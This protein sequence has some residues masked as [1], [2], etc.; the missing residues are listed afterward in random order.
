MYLRC[1][2]SVPVAPRG[3]AG[4]AGS[5]VPGLDLL[6]PGAHPL[7]L[8]L[9]PPA[10]AA[11]YRSAE[12]TC[13]HTRPHTRLHALSHRG[14]CVHTHTHTHTHGSLCVLPGSGIPELKT[15]LRGVVLKEYLTFKAFVAKVVGLTAGL[16]SGMPVGK[17]VGHVI[18]SPTVTHTQKYPGTLVLNG[19]CSC[20][21]HL[22][23]KLGGSL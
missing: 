8:T 22:G 18:W 10:G 12:N 6:P 14:T 11:S 17:E 15:I 2:S 13:T 21:G 7:L 19:P 1:A 23:S 16:G 4:S 5:A 20:S 9:L 3:A